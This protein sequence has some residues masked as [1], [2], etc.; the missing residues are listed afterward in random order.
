MDK[1][2]IKKLE[3]MGKHGCFA[4][5]L[6]QDNL[7][8][9]SL[10]LYLDFSRAC[11]ND[12]L[13]DTIDYP[14]VMGIVEGVIKGKSVRLIE[15][16]SDMIAERLFIRFPNLL[17]ADVEVEKCNVDVGFEFEEISV[18][19]SRERANYIK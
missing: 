18:K 5:E 2:S 4:A 12:N 15:K 10:D 16:L 7:F 11:K 14:S 8:K 19:I 3:I 17:K 6:E 9:I 1:I 13:E